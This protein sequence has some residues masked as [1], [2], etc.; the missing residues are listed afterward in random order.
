MRN[1]G[2]QILN[3]SGYDFEIEEPDIPVTLD[4]K[5][6]T[7]NAIRG[8]KKPVLISGL[9]V[10]GSTFRDVFAF[11]TDTASFQ[12]TDGKVVYRIEV[13]NGDSV[14]VTVVV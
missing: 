9:T 14:S 12:F 8:S 11:P 6:G 2:Y 7:T 10:N 3:L 4:V 5:A 1:G 13:N